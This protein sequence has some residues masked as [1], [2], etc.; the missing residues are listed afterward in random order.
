MNALLLNYSQ[1]SA[2]FFNILEKHQSYKKRVYICYL[3]KRLPSKKTLKKP[4]PKL[5]ISLLSSNFGDGFFRFWKLLLTALL[6]L[7]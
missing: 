4:S 2:L 5:L 3:T 1:T 6:F 7:P